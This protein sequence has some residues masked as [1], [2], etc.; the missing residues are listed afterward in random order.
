MKKLESFLKEAASGTH[1]LPLSHEGIIPGSILDARWA[2]TLR[3]WFR[4]NVMNRGKILRA[5]GKRK[6]EAWNL[7]DV[8]SSKY[9][10]KF[11]NGSLLT[12]T[13]QDRFDFS[14]SLDLKPFGIDFKAE[15][16]ETINSQIFVSEVKVQVFREGFA[17]HELRRKLRELKEVNDSRYGDVDECYLVVECFHLEGLR[18][19]FSSDALRKI[20]AVLDSNKI[21]INAQ[22]GL[23]WGGA[24]SSSLIISGTSKA[25][26][27]VRGL[28]I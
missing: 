18:W 16:D 15:F 3:N 5:L 24:S 4:V 22:A 17:G 12:G 9:A 11:E 10:S 26:I 1:I 8:D 6:G 20:K 7:L 14:G 21:D 13:L 28:K 27:A 23:E 19:E 25:P 2:T